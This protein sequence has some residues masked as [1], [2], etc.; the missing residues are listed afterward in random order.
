MNRKNAILQTISSNQQRFRALGVSEIG[1]FGSVAKGTDSPSSDV[2]LVVTFAAGQKNSRNFFG[3]C[4][5]LDEL[6]GEPYDIVTRE[7]LSPY[8]GPKILQETVYAELT[9]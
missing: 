5:L 9:S 1:V 3:L 7:G 6:V 8:I 2:D 4:D